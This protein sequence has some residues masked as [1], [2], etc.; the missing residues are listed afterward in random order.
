MVLAALKRHLLR[1]LIKICYT[2]LSNPNNG[3]LCIIYFIVLRVPSIRKR[4]NM[5]AAKHSANGS[6]PELTDI[7]VE[8][9]AEHNGFDFDD[10]EFCLY[11]ETDLEALTTFLER[12]AGPLTTEFRA[13]DTIITIEKAPDGEIS[14]E[15]EPI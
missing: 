10:P 9:I 1:P 6:K 11:D 7:L 2:F 4:D 3:L 13:F 15:V 12:T 14:A 8:K 5:A